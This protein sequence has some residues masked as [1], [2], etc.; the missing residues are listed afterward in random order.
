[1]HG[2]SDL[3]KTLPGSR[4]PFG[5]RL[6]ESGRVALRHAVTVST[7]ANARQT[8]VGQPL[9]LPSAVNTMSHRS[10]SRGLSRS[11]GA[12]V[13][14]DQ[15]ASEALHRPHLGLTAT[16]TRVAQYTTPCRPA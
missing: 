3:L 7:R 15:F 12:P 13:H 2:R 6:R 8:G 9:D 14:A 10:R 11:T 1:M 16:P 5:V 4:C